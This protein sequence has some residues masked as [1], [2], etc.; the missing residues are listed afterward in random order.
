MAQRVW[1]PFLSERDRVRSGLGGDVDHAQGVGQRAVMIHPR[2]GYDEYPP[3][4][5]AAP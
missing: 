3:A 5:D 1:E 2:L 4:H